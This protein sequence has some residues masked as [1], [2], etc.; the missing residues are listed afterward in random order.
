M[1]RALNLGTIQTR[2]HR[3]AELASDI[4]PAGVRRFAVAQRTRVPEEPD[5]GIPHVRI[6][7]GPGRVTAR[8][9]STPFLLDD[10]AR[11]PRRR[12]CRASGRRDRRHR[13]R[14]R[15]KPLIP[16]RLEPT[17]SAMAGRLV[18][19]WR[20]ATPGAGATSATWVSGR[21]GRLPAQAPHRSGR[22]EFPHPALQ[23]HGFAAQR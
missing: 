7:E 2:L 14:D 4:R 22:A 18:V 8:V 13:W 15:E 23:A 6:C 17:I 3:I 10:G 19:R 1:E 11:N 9:Y 20:P 21:P 12:C 5:A 16:T